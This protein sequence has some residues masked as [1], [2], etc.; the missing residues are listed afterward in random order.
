MVKIK[1]IKKIL[2]VDNTTIHLD[3]LKK[4]LNGNRVNVEKYNQIKNPEKY[5]LIILSGGGGFSVVNHKNEFKKEIKLIKNSKIPILGI[6]LGAELIAISFGEKL[7][8]LEIKNKGI[9]EIKKIKNDPL[10]NNLPN[11][12]KVYESHRWIIENC[13]NLIPL[14][15]SKKGSEIIKHPL[16]EI[17]GVQFHPEM[18]KNKTKGY[19]IIQNFLMMSK[20]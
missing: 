10:I 20:K 5:D 15:K 2:I 18:F 6:C 1:M 3:K 13:K 8:K 16:K 17:Y 7:E 14:A 19:K 9:I 12:F 4:S 11:K